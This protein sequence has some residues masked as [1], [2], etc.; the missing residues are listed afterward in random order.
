MKRIFVALFAAVVGLGMVVQDV[1]AKRLGGGRS[2]GMT[3]DS[4]AMKQTAPAPAPAEATAESTAES[5][6]AGGEAPAAAP[7]SAS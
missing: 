2:F 7:S 3:R 5:E 4:A 6:A 1:E